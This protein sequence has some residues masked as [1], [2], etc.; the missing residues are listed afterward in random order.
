MQKL[1]GWLFWLSCILPSVA[2]SQIINPE[3]LFGRYQ[4]FVWQDQHGLPQNG[5][6]EVVQTPDGYLWLAIAEGV[7]RFHLQFLP[8]TVIEFFRKKR[9]VQRISQTLVT[10]IFNKIGANG[11]PIANFAYLFNSSFVVKSIF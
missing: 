4:Q 8:R 1:I 11:C 3:R 10:K 5:I 2:V 7:V 9:C 6:S